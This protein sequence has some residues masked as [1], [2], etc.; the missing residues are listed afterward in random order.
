MHLLPDIVANL[1]PPCL[2]VRVFITQADWLIHITK[3]CVE[4]IFK[5]KCP[6]VQFAL[7]FGLFAR[8]AVKPNENNCVV[9]VTWA[10]K[11]GSV[12]REIILF[13]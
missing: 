3:E 6:L 2:L 4:S 13:Y 11:F 7:V 10:K 12:G 1:D 8:V 9:R 5:L